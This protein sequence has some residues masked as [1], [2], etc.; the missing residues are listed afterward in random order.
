MDV[1]SLIGQGY[2]VKDN[3]LY[4]DNRCAILLEKN[5]K[6]SSSKQTKHMDVCYFFIM[7]T[8]QPGEVTT[9]WCPTS[10]MIADYMTKPLQGKMFTKFCD[11]V[12]GIK[13]VSWKLNQ[14]IAK[15]FFSLAYSMCL[16][17]RHRSV[18]DT[19]AIQ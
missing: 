5:G 17:V 18:L 1:N 8:I 4:Q 11:I 14:W 6:L 16:W 9:E 13:L 10:E 15:Y 12:M 3:I 7:D 19:V 2:Q